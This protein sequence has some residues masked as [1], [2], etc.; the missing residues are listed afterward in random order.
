MIVARPDDGSDVAYMYCQS[1]LF[2]FM[3]WEWDTISMGGSVV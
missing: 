1:A 3:L 2:P